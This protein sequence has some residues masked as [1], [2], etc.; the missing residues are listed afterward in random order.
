MKM[1]QD[2]WDEVERLRPD[3]LDTGSGQELP[4]LYGHVKIYE[5]A[6]SISITCHWR[7]PSLNHGLDDV[8]QIE[9]GCPL[10]HEYVFRSI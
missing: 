5:D 8:P 6:A 4:F 2:F 9:L 10:P 3:T 7:Y 1:N